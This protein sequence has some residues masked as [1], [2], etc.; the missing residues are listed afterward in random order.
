MNNEELK[1]LLD[2]AEEHN[3]IGNYDEAERLVNEALATL[4]DP[5]PN[6]LPTGEG[7]KR[8]LSH[9][10]RGQGEGDFRIRALGIL[11]SAA[12]LRGNYPAA[13]EHFTSM[14]FTAEAAGDKSAIAFVLKGFGLVFMN[15][16]DYDKALEYDRRALAAY[17]ELG[18]KSGIARVTMNLGNV[19]WYLGLFNKAL[20]CCEKALAAH[21]ELGDTRMVGAVL[22]NIGNVYTELGLYDKAL[23]HY[24]NALAIFIETGAK[25]WLAN[26]K[27][28]IGNVYTSLGLYDKSLE[29]FGTALAVLEEIGAKLDMANVTGSIGSAYQSLGSYDSAL[30]YFLKALAIYEELDAKYGVASATGNIGNVYWSL[31]DYDNALEYYEKNLAAASEID[32]KLGVAVSIGNIGCVYAVKDYHGYDA[33]KAEE[34]LLKALAYSEEIDANAQIV[35]WHEYLAVLY[36]NEKRWEDFAFHYKKYHQT[37]KKVQSEDAKKMANQMEQQRQTAQY[38]K[39]IAI[40]NAAANARHLATEQLLHNVLPPSI[41]DKMLDGTKLIA[42]KLPSVSVLFADIVNFTKL[43]QRITPEELVEGLDRIFSEFDRLAEK[44]GL[45]KIKTIGDAY[46]V[47]SGAPVQHNYHA[48]AM[49]H[50]ALEMVESMKQFHSISTG[51]EIQLRIGIHSGEVVAGVIGKK[52]FAYDMWGDAVNTAARMESHGEAGKIHVSEDF[53]NALI[54]TSLSELPIQFIPRGEMDIKGKG[55]MKTYF[56][57]KT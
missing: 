47:V 12:N 27:V 8:E 30:E 25:S 45:E 17:E 6:L 50:F 52:K 44:H 26:V 43:S 28:C 54:S 46:M 24:A 13:L 53:R 3:T 33:V 5:H 4:E 41:A 23:E 48:E 34:Y 55:I 15:L 36:E 37:E 39:E 18:D 19:Y 42:E 1:A 14:Q 57:G 10:G 22:L 32:A 7:A 29:N 38:E 21:E 31:G 16:G 51:E 40:A 20:E 2:K 9:G 35:Y 11:G 56:M 49:A